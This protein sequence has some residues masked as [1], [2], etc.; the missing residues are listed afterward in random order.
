MATADSS[1]RGGLSLRRWLLYVAPPV[2]YA[3]LIFSVSAWSSPPGIPVQGGD[4]LVHFCVYALLGMLVTRALWAF[5][6]GPVRAG[7]LGALLSAGYGVLDE[8]HQMFV[9]NR[10]PELLDVA[11][12]ASGSLLGALAYLLL[13]RALRPAASPTRQEP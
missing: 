11:A 12:D 10:S 2:A 8:I 1:S 5:A 6:L 3:G 4:K 13:L 7:V 9:P